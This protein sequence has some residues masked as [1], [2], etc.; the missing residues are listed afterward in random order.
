MMA[1]TTTSI[2]RN[3]I[4]TAFQYVFQMSEKLEVVPFLAHPMLS[5]TPDISE[6][7]LPS[8]IYLIFS[9]FFFSFFA[10]S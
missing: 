7:V 10:I 4:R 2:G 6:I 5:W 9:F 1:P 3:I 8:S